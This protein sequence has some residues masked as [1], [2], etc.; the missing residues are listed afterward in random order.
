[1]PPINPDSLAAIQPELTSGES[2]LWAGQSDTRV[3]FH[4]EDLFLI[5]FSL[6]WGGF[7]IL[8][9][10]AVAGYWGS[11]GTNSGHPWVFGMIWG[12]PFVL[13]GQYVIWGRFL[14]SAWKKKR[15]HYGV[16]NRR[17]L[18]VQDGWKRH[19]ASAYIDTLPTL[20]KSGVGT[21]RFAQQES[22]WSG[23]RGRGGWDGMAVGNVPTFRDIEDVDS[24]YRLVSD[25]R[26]KTRTAK[27]TTF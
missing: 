23:R 9:E 2:V 3:I 19:M 14:Y 16:T 26:E 22:M 12:I 24:V 27:A 11:S 17:V 25:L 8:W 15:T 7:A 13:I 10:G 5:P 18:V 4:K 21:L 20:I 1:M 6:L